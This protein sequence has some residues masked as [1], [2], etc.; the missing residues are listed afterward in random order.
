[1]DIETMHRGVLERLGGGCVGTET[2]T[3]PAVD[4]STAAYE[5]LKRY[6][7]GRVL[8][9]QHTVYLHNNYRVYCNANQV[10]LVHC[11]LADDTDRM[12]SPAPLIGTSGI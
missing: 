10:S 1:M 2:S 11:R 4:L 8:D 7:R 5:S 6:L 9:G 3:C 12:P